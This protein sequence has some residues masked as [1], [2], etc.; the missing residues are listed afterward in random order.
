MKGL[1]L[2]KRYYEEYGIEMIK[3]NF[4]TYEG[5]IAVGLVG[6]GS[7]CFGF[8]DKISTDHDFGPSFIMWL[9]DEDYIQI[10]KELER[11]YKNLPREFLGYKRTFTS[12]G[13]NRVGVHKIGDFYKGFIGQ[14]KAPITLIDWM[15]IPENFLA[16]ATNGEIFRDDLGEMTKIRETLLKFY[17]EDVRIKKIAARA[18]VMA[19]S[20]QYNY[21]RCMRRNEVVAARLAIDEFIKSTISMTYLL[22]NRYTIFYKW[23]HRGMG[24]F[25]ILPEMKKKLEELIYI[26]VQNN[27]WK[28]KD[29]LCFKYN[30]NN[31]D[32]VIYKVEEICRVIIKELKRQHLTDVNSD[33]LEN[34]TNSIMSKIKNEKIKSMHIMRG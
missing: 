23:M 5:R 7:E 26:P 32:K 13:F 25:K 27:A 1:D 33:F 31:K 30:I 22:N 29:D 17:P 11:A 21:S 4:P 9:I 12:Q 34:H 10:G 28:V 3:N 18:A 19:Q 16:I 15:R 20:G 24:D 2:S 6:Q 8:D 14:S